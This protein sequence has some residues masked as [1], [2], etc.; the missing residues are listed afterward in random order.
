VVRPRRDRVGEEQQAFTISRTCCDFSN[1]LYNAF[2]PPFDGEL[3]DFF[4]NRTEAQ[5]RENINEVSSGLISFF[6]R[7]KQRWSSTH[8]SPTRW[9]CA[10]LWCKAV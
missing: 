8:G 7:R 5:A 2:A 1:R 3:T 4:F 9:E 10:I 6:T